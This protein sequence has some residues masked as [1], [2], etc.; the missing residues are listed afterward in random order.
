MN[1]KID[2]S[3][4][5]L[6]SQL[7]GEMQSPD[8]WDLLISMLQIPSSWPV[9]N[10]Q[11]DNTERRL[12]KDARN[13]FSPASMSAPPKKQQ[14]G[15]KTEKNE[16]NVMRGKKGGG[17]KIPNICLKDGEKMTEIFLSLMEDRGPQFQESQSQA[18]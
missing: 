16:S 18:R 15:I 8:P 14:R 2:L 9:S 12:G 1:Q 7:S 6:M 13:R 4:D 17:I 5:V 11:H 10:Y 3:S